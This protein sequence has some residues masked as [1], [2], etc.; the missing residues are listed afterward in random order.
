MS[1]VTYS[2]KCD[3]LMNVEPYTVGERL[4]LAQAAATQAVARATRE[5][6]GKLKYVA[7]Q[8]VRAMPSAE[9]P[10]RWLTWGDD[11]QR[12]AVAVHRVESF[13]EM[14]AGTRLNLV[15][16]SVMHTPISYGTVAMMVGA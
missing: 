16:G 13:E 10:E 8:I 2:R 15:G 9:R 5:V 3:D 14:R 6:D 12:Q 11:G 4:A 1:D 7:D